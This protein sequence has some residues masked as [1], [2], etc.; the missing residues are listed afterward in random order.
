M[1]AVTARS[2]S[3]VIGTTVALLNPTIK[4]SKK[5]QKSFGITGAIEGYYLGDD[6]HYQTLGM[7]IPPETYTGPLLEEGPVN[8]A[9]YERQ[10][11]DPL[12]IDLPPWVA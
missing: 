6:G 10:H 8:L 11:G 9:E 5:K 1:N 12:S 4:T 7:D 2:T 3:S